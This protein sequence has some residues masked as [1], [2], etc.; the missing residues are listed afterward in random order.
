LVPDVETLTGTLPPA[1]NEYVGRAATATPY[2]AAAWK[3][4]IERTYGHPGYYLLAGDG[5]RVSGVLPLF[6]VPGL[7]FGKSMTSLPFLTYGGVCADDPATGAALAEAAYRLTEEQGCDYL[8]LRHAPEQRLDLPSHEHKVAM[9]LALADSE[10]ATW[11]ALR[12][13]IRNRVRKAEK[14]GVE[15]VEGG[16]ELVPELYGVFAEN[17]RDLGSPVHSRAFFENMLTAAA[18]QAKLLVAR[19]EGETLGGG[20]TVTFRDGVEMP[21]VSSGRRHMKLAP[22]NALYWHAIR[23]ACR[24]GLKRFDFGRSTP[25]SGTFEFKR[26]WGAEPRQLYWQVLE[27]K[28]G[29]YRPG[30]DGA[31]FGLAGWM[32]QRIPVAVTRVIGPPIR[33][34]IAL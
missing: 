16:A 19:R 32:W 12:R 26:R 33:R 29:A 13:E 5:E 25:G 18:D 21:W 9:V 28:A 3:D 15:I 27:R 8:E 14:A 11:K 6:R 2:H 1:W 10:E 24:D 20:I 7:P 4:V 22:N 23:A 34:R 31:G 30:T 17:M